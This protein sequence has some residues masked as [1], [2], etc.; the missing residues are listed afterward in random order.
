M[1]ANAESGGVDGS[2]LLRKIVFPLPSMQPDLQG[3]YDILDTEPQRKFEAVISVSA[4]VRRFCIELKIKEKMNVGSTIPIPAINAAFRDVRSS[5]SPAVII[6]HLISQLLANDVKAIP[7]FALTAL[8]QTADMEAV[9]DDAYVQLSM[10]D[11]KALDA[12]VSYKVSSGRTGVVS[13]GPVYPRR[14][15]GTAGMPRRPSSS[16]GGSPGY[17]PPALPKTP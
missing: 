9:A 17:P 12:L 2:S 1:G 6:A 15:H 3:L 10:S 8:Q 13:A 14:L 16:G 11:R 5:A 4:A 7:A